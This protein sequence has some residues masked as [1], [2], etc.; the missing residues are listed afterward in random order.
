MHKLSNACSLG[1]LAE[2]LVPGADVNPVTLHSAI[3]YIYIYIYNYLVSSVHVRPALEEGDDSARV[4]RVASHRHEQGCVLILPSPK[5]R[6]RSI[7]TAKLNGK[8]PTSPNTL[9]H[10]RL[11]STEIAVRDT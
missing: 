6:T 2:F 4:R 5:K 8:T 1:A 11:S 3:I 9:T 10:G 7:E